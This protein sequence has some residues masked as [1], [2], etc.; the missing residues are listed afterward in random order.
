MTVDDVPYG[1]SIKIV[2]NVVPD[3]DPSDLARIEVL[4]GPQGALYGAGS[5]GGLLKYVTVDP[6]I[7]GFSG[8]VQAD[9]N[10]VYNGAEPGYSVRGAVNI[11]IMDTIAIRASAFSREDPGYVDNPILGINGVNEDRV[12]GARLS[13]LLQPSETFSLK[14]SALYQDTRGDGVNDVDS[15][16]PG[17]E[18]NYI[19]GVGQ[20]DKRLQA[21]SAVAKLE[22]AKIEITSVTGYNI[23]KW[24]TS[25]D[26]TGAFGGLAEAALGQA[27]APLFSSGKTDKLTQEIRVTIPFGN[28]FDLLAGVF[29]T[30]EDSL[31]A[32]ALAA[33]NIETGELVG[34]LVADHSPTIYKE[35]AGFA[36]LTVHVTDR[37]D[38]QLGGRESRI[39]QDFGA[40][41]DTG[42]LYG[43]GSIVPGAQTS[44]NA[45][46]YLV[47]PRFV[48][49]P[50]LMVYA[51]AASGYRPG[52]S[53]SS[54]ADPGVPRAYSPDKTQNYELGAKGDILEHALSFDASFYYIDWKDI[55]LTELDAEHLGYGTNGSRAKSEG[56]ELSFAARPLTRLAIT[57][58][59]TYGDAALT[60][61]M[62]ANSAVYGVSG[63]RLPY[64]PRFASHFSI[65]QEFPLANDLT[66]IVG[67]A[68]S[69]VGARFGQFVDSP[70]RQAYPDYTR[71]DVHIGLTHGGW[72]ANFYVNNI[73]NIR[74][75]VGGGI[76][77]TPNIFY[78]IQPRTIGLSL[79]NRF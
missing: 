61:A 75:L 56:V 69:Y 9:V 20:Y 64:S 31:F 78:Y 46:T 15:T 11:P 4:R 59:G 34:T 2:G 50:D 45:F 37:F 35:Y 36:D 48:V 54:N 29:Y 23:N 52:G 3:F 67:G 65:D 41:P 18:Q 42:V 8:Q 32:E 62:P 10:S 6:S 43:T 16:L 28:R 60:E 55:Q 71:T 14:A 68:L 22:L 72:K 47:T 5:M 76:G 44:A 19:R 63:D 66:G 51:R 38:I 73:A 33:E 49:S 57:L 26:A 27:G 25:L 30:H 7:K 12:N 58:W 13:T 40:T 53:N 74:G 70:Q 17:L 24:E 1:S 21:Y 79:T 39:D 77:A